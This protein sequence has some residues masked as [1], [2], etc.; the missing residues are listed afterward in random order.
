MVLGDAA[1]WSHGE[2][3]PAR[4]ILGHLQRAALIPAE[5]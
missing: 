5:F 3:I 4:E 2:T 1:A